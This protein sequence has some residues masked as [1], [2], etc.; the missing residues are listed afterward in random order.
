MQV[1]FGLRSALGDSVS[2][3]GLEGKLSDNLSNKKLLDR[4]PVV[5]PT[6]KRINIPG[7]PPWRG[8]GCSTSRPQA[9][10]RISLAGPRNKGPKP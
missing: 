9:Q 5:G 3:T 10:G 2:F 6:L 8:E 7:R 4:L 1:L